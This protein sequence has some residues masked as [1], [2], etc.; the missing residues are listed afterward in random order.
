MTELK[1]KV[2]NSGRGTLESRSFK[3][4]VKLGPPTLK[5]I[6]LLHE[7][8]A[9]FNLFCLGWSTISSNPWRTCTGGDCEKSQFANSTESRGLK[10]HTYIYIVIHMH[11]FIHLITLY[12]ACSIS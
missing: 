9:V 6:T 11:G 2:R 1:A 12:N 8:R 7:A 5:M 10:R 3:D 4:N